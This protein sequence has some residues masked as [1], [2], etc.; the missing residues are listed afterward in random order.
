MK[1]VPERRA[2]LALAAAAVAVTVVGGIN[3]RADAAA[4]S[5]GI[6]VQR[7]GGDADF[8]GS[9]TAPAATGTAI[10]FDEFSLTTNTRLQ[11]V[12]LPTT[13][14]DGA[15]AQRRIVDTGNSASVGYVSRSADGNYLVTGGYDLAVG[16]VTGGVSSTNNRIIARVDGLGVI[17]TSTGYSQDG[18][19]GNNA[20]LRSVATSNGTSFYAGTANGT[21]N[22][23]Y[24]DP[25]GTIDSATDGVGGPAVRTVGVFGNRLF[26]ASNG[27]TSVKNTASGGL[28]VGPVADNTVAALTGITNTNTQQ[29][30]MLDLV[31]GV[32]YDGTGVD[33]LYLTNANNISATPN[34]TSAT[35][36]TG[37]L[38]KYV[39][40]GTNWVQQVTFNSGL[41]S[42]N[43][44]PLFGGLQGVAFA[45][46]DGSG[47]PILY[48]TTDAPTTTGNALVRLVDTGLASAFTLVANAP[49]NTMFRGVALA[50]V[51]EPGSIALI[52]IGAL[53]LLGR[54]RR[55]D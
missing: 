11:T 9:G 34:P 19:A 4:F 45:G 29:F 1:F 3:S 31:A 51:P 23:R 16:D 5:G 21:A 15:G 17:D 26:V 55:K 25:F 38:Q 28:P 8:G 7:M 32:G 53:G 10:F 54:R 52:G 2:H 24:V 49:T 41:S 33:T 47:N 35:E 14:P 20:T 50:P 6:V 18:S 43:T 42:T 27:M 30:T 36:D 44:S 39:F 12:A 22:T 13:D 46:F 40:D 48:A 37:G